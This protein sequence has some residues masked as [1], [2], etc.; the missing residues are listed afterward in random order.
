MERGSFI[1]GISSINAYYSEHGMSVY[2]S[3]KAALLQFARTAA[4]D[5]GI[6]SIRV[7]VVAPGYVK[8][9]QTIEELRNPETKKRIESATVLKRIGELE[10]VSPIVVALTS[11]DFRFITDTYIEISRGLAL[12]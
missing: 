7:N 6:K 3:T 4:A 1:I 5:L 2:D 12:T 10:D 9:P 8:T 11:D